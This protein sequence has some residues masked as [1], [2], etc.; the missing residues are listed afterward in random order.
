MTDY[1]VYIT[2]NELYRVARSADNHVYQQSGFLK[3]YLCYHCRVYQAGSS[4]SEL[5]RCTAETT[6]DTIIAR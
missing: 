4:Y 3:A 6:A 2:V 5:V 1:T